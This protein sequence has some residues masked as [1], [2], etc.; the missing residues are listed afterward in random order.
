MP[1]SLYDVIIIGSGPA[2]LAAAESARETGALHI[3]I[4]E[5]AKRLGGECPN[6]GCVPTKALLRSASVLRSAREAK[7]FGVDISD[8]KFDFSAM[9]SR[10][11]RIVDSLTRDSRMEGILKK[12]NVDLI[13]GQATFLDSKTVRVGKRKFQSR[14]FV[15]ATGSKTFIPPID[16]IHDVPY[17]TSDDLVNLKQLPTSMCIVGGGPI[18]IEF[19]DLFQTLGVRVSIIEY[20]PRVLS[21]EDED[22][23]E[24]IQKSFQ[25]RGIAINTSTETSSVRHNGN[26]FQITIKKVNDDSKRTKRI[27]AELFV[28]ATGKRPAIE[29]LSLEKAKIQLDKRGSP[30]LDS[31][32]RTTNRRVYMAGDSAGQMM[33]THVAHMQGEVAGTNAVL[34]KSKRSVLRVVPRGVFCTPE[35]GSVGFT[36]QEAEEHGHRIVTGIGYYSSV[37]K[38]LVSGSKDGFAK[39]IV[40]TKTRLILGGHIVGHSASE[41]IHEVA[42]AMQA[43]TP[44]TVVANMIHAYPTFAEVIGV[45]AYDAVQKMK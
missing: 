4:I 3:A 14:A 7:E 17:S 35:I 19:A 16:G 41:I 25:A 12:M 9:M 5:S 43:N 44:V 11:N 45:S 32:L 34:H 23:S 36:E 18:G 30:I 8:P 37:G 26:A 31:Y 29:T 33:F 22:I 10:K 40:D 2:G 39:I 27:D 28:I 20:A 38:S 24:Y 21:H 15:I 13:R 6:W 1:V 42:L